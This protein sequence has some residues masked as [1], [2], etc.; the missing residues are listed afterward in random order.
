MTVMG[1]EMTVRMVRGDQMGTR[2]EIPDS[3]ILTCLHTWLSLMDGDPHL[4]L[5]KGCI[6]ITRSNRWTT[7]GGRKEIRTDEIKIIDPIIVM[8]RN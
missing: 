7:K 4:T 6:Q 1:L 5:I 2:E 8:K 3:S